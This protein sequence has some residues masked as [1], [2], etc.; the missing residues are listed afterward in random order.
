V[1]RPTPKEVAAGFST[2]AAVAEAI[3][4]LGSAP[5]GPIYAALMHQTGM[6][7][8][9]FEAILRILRNADLV[10]RRGDLLVWVGPRLSGGVS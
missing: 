5:A 7:M 10:E 9:S 1:S 3:R 2:V 4:E 8:Q 6:D